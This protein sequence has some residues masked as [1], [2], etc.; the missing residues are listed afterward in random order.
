MKRQSRSTGAGLIAQLADVP[1]TLHEM[2]CSAGSAREAQAGDDGGPAAE[3]ADSGSVGRE[4]A[5]VC[6]QLG[7]AAECLVLRF[8]SRMRSPGVRPLMRVCWAPKF[9]EG[10]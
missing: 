5:W 2:V 8:K 6:R 10:L 4:R 1:A 3:P 9:L 7:R